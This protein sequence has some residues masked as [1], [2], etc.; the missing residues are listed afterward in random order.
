V[1]EKCDYVGIGPLRFT[2]T[3]EKLSPVLG[4]EGF[5]KTIVELKNKNIHIPVYAI[6]GIVLEDV[7]QLIQAGVY[8]IAVSGIITNHSDKKTLIEQLNTHLHATT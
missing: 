2:T 8:G 3:K 1:E 5:Q 4:I 6:G 7:N